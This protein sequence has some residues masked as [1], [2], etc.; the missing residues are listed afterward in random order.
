LADVINCQLTTL[1]SI[2]IRFC[3]EWDRSGQ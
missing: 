1:W 2:L 3:V